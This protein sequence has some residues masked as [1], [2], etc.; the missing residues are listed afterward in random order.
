MLPS[1]LTDG[2]P[3]VAAGWTLPAPD[4]AAGVRGGRGA[5]AGIRR[6]GALA[7]G[8]VTDGFDA[9]DADDAPGALAALTGYERW[10]RTQRAEQQ[11]A[12]AYARV[13]GARSPSARV[14]A[15]P[16][17]LRRVRQLL[18]LRLVAVAGDRRRAFPQ[19]VPPARNHGIAALWA[20]V[21]WAARARSPDDDSGVL[22][23]ADASIRGLLSLTPSD[24]ADPDTVRSWRKRLR[25]VEETLHGLEM[26]AQVTVEGLQAAVDDDQRLER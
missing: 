16:E 15:A 3:V 25:L 17:F 11:V 10:D 14:A 24:L 8:H 21:F 4:P 12:A 26:E 22:E 18:A 5:S 19:R 6:Q 23:A 1:R 2:V 20:E 9:D 13:I 7:F